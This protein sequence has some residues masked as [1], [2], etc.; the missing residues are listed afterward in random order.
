MPAW[1]RVPI[2]ATP[3][4]FEA[5]REYD[6]Q[7]A[8]AFGKFVDEAATTLRRRS[9]GAD[10]SWPRCKWSTGSP[11]NGF[12]TASS[13]P[14]WRTASRRY[15]PMI[16]K[17]THSYLAAGLPSTT[18]ITA[19]HVAGGWSATRNLAA[20]ALLVEPWLRNPRLERCFDLKHVEGLMAGCRAFHCGVPWK[21]WPPT[22]DDLATGGA[23]II[24]AM[25]RW[26]GAAAADALTAL[27]PA[28]E[29]RQRARAH[30]RAGLS[31]GALLPTPYAAKPPEADS[32]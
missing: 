10:S 13:A 24:A 31:S 2:D 32:S 15:R 19:A 11:K 7:V 26:G 27:V 9:G 3:E 17:H 25:L 12:P 14:R 4:E 6:S 29:P 18:E 20:L 22:V 30:C 28:G 21:T 16:Q 23:G 5:A 8:L 1:E